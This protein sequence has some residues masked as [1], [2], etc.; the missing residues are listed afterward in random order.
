MLR[1]GIR[2][3]NARQNPSA[4]KFGVGFASDSSLVRP[5]QYGWPAPPGFSRGW[6]VAH[7]VGRAGQSDGTGQS[8]SSA[9]VATLAGIATHSIAP[10]TSIVVA[11]SCASNIAYANLT[12]VKSATIMKAWAMCPKLV[13]KKAIE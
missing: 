6:N 13:T 8:W 9:T 3:G 5:E 4:K 2:L 7:R 11:A 10:G 12:C 1:L